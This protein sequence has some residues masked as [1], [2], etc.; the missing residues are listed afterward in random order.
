MSGKLLIEWRHTLCMEIAK[1]RY[2]DNDITCMAHKELVNIF[3]P[4]E[5]SEA[6]EDENSE[7]HS[8]KSSEN[9]KKK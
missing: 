1:K 5:I 3:F 8:E 9:K 7:H 2:M 4:Q 6:D